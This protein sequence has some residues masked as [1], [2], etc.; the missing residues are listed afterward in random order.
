MNLL[1]VFPKPM[2]LLD[3]KARDKKGAIRELLSHLVKEG[4]L[5]E[6]ASKKAEKGIQKR[7]SQ[8]STGVGKGLAIPHAKSCAQVE[9]VLGVFGR[10]AEGIAFDAVDG[11]FV[12]VIFLIVSAEDQA[13]SHLAVMRK[14]ATLARDEKSLRF[15]A[16]TG[17]PD[18]M[19]EIFKE[20]DDGQ[21]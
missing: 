20:I 10:S 3:L 9:G 7:E 19:L 13:D 16:S 21:L 4:K 8:G 15:L 17:N 6:E 5:S 2:L 14:V 18:G 11:E 1:D 12:N